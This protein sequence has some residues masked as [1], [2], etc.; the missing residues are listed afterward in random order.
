MRILVVNRFAGTE[1]RERTNLD[2]KLSQYKQ[3]S[4][5]L[6]KNLNKVSDA[7]PRLARLAVRSKKP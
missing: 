6:S 7:A 3:G 4:S 5:Q 2:Q 1:F